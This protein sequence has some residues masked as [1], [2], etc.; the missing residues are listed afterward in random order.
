MGVVNYEKEDNIGIITINRPQALNALS[1]EVLYEL[2]TI[3][4]Q[5][6]ED[7]RVKVV[8]ITGMGD[9][10]FVAGADIAE[11]VAKTVDEGYRY[12]RLGQEIFSMIESLPQPVI[13]VVNGYALGGGCELAM[14]CDLRIASEK[15]RFGQP[16]I[17]LGI[18]PGYG[19]TQRLPRL[20]GKTKAMELLLTAD[21]IGAAEAERLGL[22][23]TVVPADKLMDTAKAMANKIAAKGQI[24]I[25]ATKAAVN[26]GLQA[27]IDTACAYEAGL[28]G[29]CFAS[30]DRK[31]GMA[32]FMEKRPAKFQD[33]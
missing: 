15:A 23:N 3:L 32:A 13:A 5:I 16:E 6:K 30:E 25:R 14:A 4:Q 9:K 19:G 1:T 7:S 21:M 26:K 27:D 17:N 22:V 20:I 10:A 2:R 33:R 12:S 29:V 31:E 24:A 8:I 18:I 28:F 11:M